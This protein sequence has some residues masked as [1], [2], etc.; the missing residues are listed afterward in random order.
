MLLISLEFWWSGVKGLSITGFVCLWMQS[1]VAPQLIFVPMS[2]LFTTSVYFRVY[3]LRLDSW[4]R[5]NVTLGLGGAFHSWKAQDLLGCWPSTEIFLL[6]QIHFLF[7]LF[8][9]VSV[10]PQDCLFLARN[11]KHA[12]CVYPEKHPPTSGMRVHTRSLIVAVQ[13]ERGCFLY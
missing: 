7:C 3:V 4:R 12:L 8:L 6:S 11:I 2:L 5:R 9:S 13:T 1:M 10:W